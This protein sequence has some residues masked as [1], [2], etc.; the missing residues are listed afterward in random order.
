MQTEIFVSTAPMVKADKQRRKPHGLFKK[1]PGSE[2]WWIRHADATGRIRREKAGVDLRTVQE[3]MGH[4]T[5]AMTV[6]Y[7]HLAPAHRREAVERLV[8]AA[9]QTS[10]PTEADTLSQAP[11]DT[12]TSTGQI[13]ENP[14]EAEHRVQVQ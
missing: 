4:K 10:K 11:T 12:K 5:I 7:S 1:V 9:S 2:L 8:R 13:W 6:R 3:L 14:P